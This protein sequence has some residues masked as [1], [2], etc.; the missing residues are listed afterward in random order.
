[1]AVV[2]KRYGTKRILI[3]SMTINCIICILTPV[4]ADT[5]GSYGMMACRALQGFAQAG[6][7]PALYSVLSQWA[8]PA[9]RSFLGALGGS[10][11]LLGVIVTM[12]VTG[13]LCS[14]SWGWP[15][16]FYFNGALGVMWLALWIV[17]AADT[18]FDH[19]FISQVEKKYIASSLDHEENAKYRATPWTKILTSLPFLGITLAQFGCSWGDNIS[20]IE[21]PSYINKIL[22]YNIDAN[23]VVS[24]LPFLAN[25]ILGF[26]FGYVAD[27]V[28]RKRIMSLETCRKVF[29]TI[30]TVGPA[31]CLV[32]LSFLPENATILSCVL[33]VLH[34][35]F[36][37]AYQGGISMSYLDI[38]PNFCAILMSITNAVCTI[39]DIVVPLLVQVIVTDESNKSQWTIIFLIAAA[40]YIF[41]TVAFVFLGSGKVQSWDDITDKKAAVDSDDTEN[42]NTD[43]NK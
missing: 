6:V 34:Q 28:I 14:S 37:A 9:E 32:S 36:S 24:S 43:I 39:C 26:I 19:K 21:M 13:F 4:T 35:S 18:P 11:S 23:G 15:S 42:C 38:S 25:F 31:I 5:F 22:K 8:P 10:G 1:M 29:V 17:L 33:M 41:A 2:M 30:S 12:P 3:I 27:T 20:F 7:L 40:M 16:S